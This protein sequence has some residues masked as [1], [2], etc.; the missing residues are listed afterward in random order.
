MPE[1][2]LEALDRL[3]DRK[4]DPIK[5]V[6]SQLATSEEIQAVKTELTQ[7]KTTVKTQTAVIQEKNQIVVPDRIRR[8]ARLK[9]GAQVEFRATPGVITI[10]TKPPATDGE[11]TSEQRRII[12]TRLAKAEGDVKA[13]RVHGP[14]SSAKEASVYLER[15]AKER[16]TAKSAKPQRR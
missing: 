14:F 4:L 6:I 16:A 5:T 11:Y 8:R 1:L 13:G 10:I 9:P 2:T 15:L 3:L 7:V 12:D